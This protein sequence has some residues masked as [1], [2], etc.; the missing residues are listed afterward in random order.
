MK[1][2][3]R[4]IAFED[5]L[6]DDWRRDLDV[7]EV[8]IGGQP[9]RY[10]AIAIAVAVLAIAGRI[11]FLGLNYGYYTVRAGQNGAVGDVFEDG[12]FGGEY[13]YVHLFFEIVIVET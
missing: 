9:M 3:D 4:D 2:R 1:R 12:L 7:A 10:L 13:F 6:S 5:A 8:S 11:V